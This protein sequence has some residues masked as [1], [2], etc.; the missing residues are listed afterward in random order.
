MKSHTH[1]HADYEIVVPSNSALSI[2]FGISMSH[3]NMEM[4]LLL[5]VTCFFF[6]FK[7]VSLARFFV[8]QFWL[9]FALKIV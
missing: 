1:K 9:L 6:A 3:G 7:H 5:N 4:V 8:D 2:S